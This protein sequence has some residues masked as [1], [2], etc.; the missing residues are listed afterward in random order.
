MLEWHTS[1]QGPTLTKLFNII[2]FPHKFMRKN[3]VWSDDIFEELGASSVGKLASKNPHLQSW[4]GG[5]PKIPAGEVEANRSQWLT[6]ANLN[7]LG[8]C[9]VS[10]TPCLK[11]QDGQTLRNNIQGSSSSTP[12]PVSRTHVHVYMCIHIYRNHKNSSDFQNWKT[13]TASPLISCFFSLPRQLTSFLHVR[14]STASSKH[15]YQEDKA[16]SHHFESSCRSR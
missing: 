3:K 8:K 14:E 10:E 7:P 4:H 5:T 2:T 1:V 11:N 16:N 9:Q 15:T 6:P 12:M 13:L